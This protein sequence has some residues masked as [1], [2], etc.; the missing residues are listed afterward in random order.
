MHDV[1]GGKEGYYNHRKAVHENTPVDHTLPC[2]MCGKHFPEQDSTGLSRNYFR[3]W[4]KHF[5]FE[6]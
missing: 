1:L 6:E 2:D 3:H 5:Y 4:I